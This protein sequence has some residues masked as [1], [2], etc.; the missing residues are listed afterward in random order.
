VIA[1]LEPIVGSPVELEELKH[2]PGR[3]RTLRARGPLR[4]AIVKLYASD[5]AATVAARVAALAAGP[6][7]PVLPRVLACSSEDRMVVLSEVQGRTLTGAL[8]AGD[9]AACRRAG[10]ALGTWHRAWSGRAPE[11]LRRH[12]VERELEILDLRAATLSP[13]LAAD[14]RTAV[15]DLTEPWDCPT[16]VH[17]DLYEEQILLGDRVGLIDLDDAA[18]GPPELD[19][20]NLLAHLDL[21]SLR[22]GRELD[23]MSA[24]MLAGYESAGGGFEEPLLDRCR[25]L[26]RVRLACIHSEPAFIPLP[27]SPNGPPTSS[28]AS[29]RAD[30][31]APR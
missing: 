15:E 29:G 25:R 17:R 3:R 24:A 6:P 11:P 8:L 5:R 9:R 20:G 1:R 14:L 21:L 10:E 31:G 4:T 13:G 30:L 22:S 27:I 28:A 2:K 26:A 7:E 19:L 23:A 18:L 16:V 12:G